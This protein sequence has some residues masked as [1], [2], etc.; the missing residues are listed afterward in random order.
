MNWREPEGL[1]LDI[2]NTWSKI[3]RVAAS[4]VGE[5]GYLLLALDGADGGSR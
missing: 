2:P 4:L 3:E 5:C 1:H